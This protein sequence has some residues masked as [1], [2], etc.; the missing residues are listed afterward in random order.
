MSK[1]V[2]QILASILEDYARCEKDNDAFEAKSLFRLL[3]YCPPAEPPSPLAEK[4][5]PRD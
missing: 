1:Y 2:K 5:V 3:N 4:P